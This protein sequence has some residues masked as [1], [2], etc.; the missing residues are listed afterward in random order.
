MDINATFI[1]QIIV[2]LIM[3]WFIAKVVVPM[4]AAPISERHKKIADGLAAAERGQKDLLAAESRVDAIVREARARAQQ[5]EA[6]AQAQANE[7]IEAAKR[8][9]TVEGARILQ[10]AEQQIAL[11]RQSARD[12][13]RQQVAALAVAGAGKIIEREI[14][15]RA[16]AQLL[17]KLVTQI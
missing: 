17:D 16:H 13:L 11:E 3:L 4:I 2:F 6:Q 7:I 8:S 14:D 15:P 1:G 12:E 10:S 5:I 9:A